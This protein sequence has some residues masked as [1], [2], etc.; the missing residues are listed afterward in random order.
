MTNPMTPLPDLKPFDE[1]ETAE[2]ARLLQHI[3][4][5]CAQM[6]DAERAVVELGIERRQTVARL[7]EHNVPWKKIA[8]WAGTTTQALFKHH[9]RGK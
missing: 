7:G 4:D 6:R 8:E 9:N 3:K 1:N 5:I 2:V